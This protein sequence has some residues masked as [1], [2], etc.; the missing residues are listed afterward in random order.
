MAVVVVF[1]S[2]IINSAISYMTA[3]C[4]LKAGR[5][6]HFTVPCA[7][8][9]RETLFA[10]FLRHES[11]RLRVVGRI[12][13]DLWSGSSVNSFGITLAFQAVSRPLNRFRISG[14]SYSYMV[15]LFALA[16]NLASRGVSV[17][18]SAR[19]VLSKASP[20]LIRFFV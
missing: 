4:S 18:N 2:A 5:D 17:G 20:M 19:N 16:A 14:G 13:K 10:S 9:A 1:S 15:A 11:L 6:K 8:K 7:G 3:P 12:V